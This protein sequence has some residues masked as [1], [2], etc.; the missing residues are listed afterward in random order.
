[1]VLSLSPHFPVS[2]T[3]GHCLEMLKR[4]PPVRKEPNP[5]SPS[6]LLDSYLSRMRSGKLKAWE[7]R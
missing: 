3:P 6:V 1:M 2:C 4:T 5:C 7:L